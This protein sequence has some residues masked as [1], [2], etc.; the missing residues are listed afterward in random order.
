MKPDQILASLSQLDHH[1]RPVTL[2]AIVFFSLVCLSLGGM[3]GWSLY[4]ARKVQLQAAT[5]A[6]ANITHALGDHVAHG[7][8]LADSML[9][10]LVERVQLQAE[11]SDTESLA[12]YLDERTRRSALVQALA[13]YDELGQLAPGATVPA[14]PAPTV[15]QHLAHHAGAPDDALF[16]GAPLRGAGG[17]WLLPLSR[18]VQKR[19]GSFG[20]IAMSTLSIA[21]LRDFTGDLDIGQRGKLLLALEA[22]PLVLAWPP[23]DADV[24]KDMRAAPAFMLW[25]RQLGAPGAAIVPAPA[26]AGGGDTLYS[27]RRVARYPL[28][29][30]LARP[31]DDVL[32]AWWDSAYLST[33]GVSLLLLIQLWLGIR[34]YGQIT[35][36]D[37]LEKDRRSLQKLLVKKSRSLR[38][39]ALKDALT[40]VANRRQFDIRLNWEFNRAI[41][42]G[43]S[44]ALVMLDVDYFKKYND[45][46]GHPAGD[47]CLKLV[48]ACVSG[49]RRRSDDLAARLGGEEF[50]ILLPNTG[51]RG[52]IAVAEAIRKSVAAHR[53]THVAGASHSVTISC[54]VHAV[55]PVEGMSVAE[56][57]DAADRALYLAKTSG[58]NRVRAEGTMPPTGAKRLSLVIN[59]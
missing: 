50:A 53:M 20:G 5:Q 14:A 3:Q 1:K 25:R 35:L 18:R 34:L 56:L 31:T 13:V 21:L 26:S 41:D 47:E 28:M 23:A 36:R 11:L 15:L 30:A 32:T 45:R 29:V 51:L 54:G 39:Q 16:I 58:R 17:G 33:A 7:L 12:R 2:V 52:A 8:D 37:R 59:K 57:M 24:G 9:S 4:K 6:S 55:V 43:A 44:L 22:G 40:G 46:Y 27:Y 49:G 19:D 10:D 42:E 38:R 48:A